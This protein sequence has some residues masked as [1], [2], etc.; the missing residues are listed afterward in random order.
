MDTLQCPRCRAQAVE[1]LQDSFARCSVCGRS[2]RITDRGTLVERWL[3][4]LSLVLYPV[5]F[6]RHPQ[7]VAV[8]VAQ[9]L[10]TGTGFRKFSD[11]ELREIL[12]EIRSELQHP[13]Q[14]V[15]EILDCEASESDLRQYLAGVADQLDCLL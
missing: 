15:R 10:R 8:Q 11:A 2:F 6:D 1:L 9:N 7:T 5:Q 4:P 3:G 12:L 14:E 13:T